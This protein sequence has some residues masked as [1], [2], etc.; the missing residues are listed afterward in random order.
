[1]IPPA[2]AHSYPP[3]LSLSFLRYVFV[4]ETLIALAVLYYCTLLYI[5]VTS[6]AYPDKFCRA[7]TTK[8]FRRTL[9]QNFP[10]PIS[11]NYTYDVAGLILLNRR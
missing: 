3:R 4:I 1:M 6:R 10:I 9:F 11:K 5:C 2:S 8:G 7:D